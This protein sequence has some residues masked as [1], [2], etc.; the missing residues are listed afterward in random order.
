[1]E[2]FIQECIKN[3]GTN[4]KGSAS[5]LVCLFKNVHVAISDKV[6]ELKDRGLFASIATNSRPDMHL[7]ECLSNYKL[8]IVPRSLS[9][10]DGIMLHFPAKSKLME[11]LEK[12]SS[13]ETSDVVPP[14]K[15][16]PNKCDN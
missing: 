15:R 5:N 1:M 11:I 4:A 6:V 12:M 14:D 13:A 16:Q 2:T 3:F 9:A 8:S 7:R 10:A